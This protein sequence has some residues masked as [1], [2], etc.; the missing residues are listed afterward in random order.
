MP[1]SETSQVTDAFYIDGA[2][3]NFITQNIESIG[4]LPAEV[5]KLVRQATVER[6]VSKPAHWLHLQSLHRMAD[7]EAI[8]SSDYESARQA[9]VADVLRLAIE[10]VEQYGFHTSSKAVNMAQLLVEAGYYRSVMQD[11]EHNQR[12]QQ[13]IRQPQKS[14]LPLLQRHQHYSHTIIQL[15]C[16]INNLLRSI[17]TNRGI[18]FQSEKN[19]EM[20]SQVL[21]SANTL[22]HKKTGY[23]LDK[24]IQSLIL[25]IR[26]VMPTVPIDSQLMK[27]I[28][29]LALLMQTICKDYY[30]LKED[31][32]ALQPDDKALLDMFQIKI[33]SPKQ[34]AQTNISEQL[35]R[36]V[37]LAKGVGRVGTSMAGALQSGLVAKNHIDM[38]AN[39]VTTGVGALEIYDAAIDDGP[40]VGQY[41]GQLYNNLSNRNTLAPLKALLNLSY[42]PVKVD[43]LFC[44][45]AYWYLNF[46]KIIMKQGL[47]EWQKK[48]AFDAYTKTLAGTN[49]HLQ[50][51]AYE[52]FEAAYSDL[53]FLHPVERETPIFQQRALT[54]EY[55]RLQAWLSPWC[56]NY[57]RASTENGKLK[58][59]LA[60]YERITSHERSLLD[61]ASL[62]VTS[63]IMTDISVALMTFPEV[64]IIETDA[65]KNKL[66]NILNTAYKN[67]LLNAIVHAIDNIDDYTEKGEFADSAEP[68]LKRYYR[69]LKQGVLLKSAE[70]NHIAILLPSTKEAVEICRNYREA[71]ISRGIYNLENENVAFDKIKT[72]YITT[73]KVLAKPLKKILNGALTVAVE[74]MRARIDE[75]NALLEVLSPDS[76]LHAI[77]TEK[78]RY[79]DALL[80]LFTSLKRQLSRGTLAHDLAERIARLQQGYPMTDAANE[81]DAKQQSM[82]KKVGSF[83]WNILPTSQQPDDIN[84]KMIRS[85]LDLMMSESQKNAQHTL[86]NVNDSYR[87]YQQLMKATDVS[88][89]T[90]LLVDP[91]NQLPPTAEVLDYIVMA[92]QDQLGVKVQRHTLQ[93]L[94]RKV[95]L[96]I[97]K[98]NWFGFA[99]EQ[100]LTSDLFIDAV[101]KIFRQVVDFKSLSTD[102]KK[103]FFQLVGIGQ[104]DDLFTQSGRYVNGDRAHVDSFANVFLR[105]THCQAQANDT[106][107]SIELLS[108]LC[109]SWNNIWQKHAVL[110]AIQSDS[111]RALRQSILD[112]ESLTEFTN[113]IELGRADQV[114]ILKQRLIVLLG[115]AKHDVPEIAREKR[116]AVAESLGTLLRNNPN[117]HELPDSLD[118]I[119]LQLQ[120]SARVAVATQLET[121]NR[122]VHLAHE[123]VDEKLHPKFGINNSNNL[124]LAELARRRA[125]W[126]Y[127]L[128]S[129]GKDIVGFIS[130]GLIWGKYIFTL[131]TI[132]V[133]GSGMASSVVGAL[134]LG[135]SF[136]NPLSAFISSIVILS[137]GISTAYNALKEI[138][139]ERDTF[140]AIKT[141][142]DLR[143]FGRGTR[144][145]GTAAKIIGKML[146]KTIFTGMLYARIQ[147]AGVGFLQRLHSSIIGSQSITTVQKQEAVLQKIGNSLTD[148]QQFLS[149]VDM[150]FEKSRKIV[151]YI[152]TETAYADEDKKAQGISDSF[153]FGPLAQ[154]CESYQKTA[155][156]FKPAPIALSVVVDADH[157]VVAAPS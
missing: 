99:I 154:E 104:S 32:I 41:L 121:A 23:K 74:Q 69:K 88:E 34:I 68:F 38:L 109:P 18:N 67:F 7:G 22:I 58:A 140:K 61:G 153:S 8:I 13:W 6:L 3:L 83:V 35:Q 77:L 136:A 130:A 30:E 124:I 64:D 15:P 148:A 142:T 107:S 12:L 86:L 139:W 53:I 19:A 57:M 103:A 65:L 33:Q 44:Q 47:S 76:N 1:Q 115:E 152:S 90:F 45:H 2:F 36:G 73:K 9:F 105:F 51:A 25:A 96:L 118:D 14:L 60:I 100:L 116:E 37:N 66:N 150:E 40:G 95:A 157:E 55:A 134:G 119:K 24:I 81:L 17:S 156:F 108:R 5:L 54:N 48:S 50:W 97:T 28:Q 49:V 122:K 120:I 26:I 42:D 137:L 59:V 117:C 43:K 112:N 72:E 145:L 85:A 98:T 62:K 80:S 141:R 126:V 102:V 114:A 147:K 16:A 127:G 27:D 125:D 144:Y 87:A 82:C 89:H 94:S 84:E 21:H 93:V 4:G 123:H 131:Y 155:A 106:V 151:E 56:N 101:G 10:K 91:L 75:L 63:E 52:T 133:A 149:R 113:R 78:L 129:T 128:T 70:I 110:S 111:L 46:F 29:E 92:I 71:L 135:L 11:I 132:I 138:N 143:G 146:F 20:L 31:M 39:I 79:T